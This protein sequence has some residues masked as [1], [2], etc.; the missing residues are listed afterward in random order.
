[1][2]IEVIDE[3]VSACLSNMVVG[4]RLLALIEAARL[5]GFGAPRSSSCEGIRVLP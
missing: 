4:S 1:M 2:R 3:G 5:E